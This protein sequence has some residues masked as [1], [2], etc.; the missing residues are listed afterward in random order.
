MANSLIQRQRET[1]NLRFGM[2]LH[3]NSATFQ[4]A[5]GDTV[6]WEYDCE[7]NDVPRQHPFS[8][9]DWNPQELD[10]AQWA[11][12]A[13]EAGAAFG[14]L[15]AKHHEGFCLW[16]THYTE[17]CV[18]SA[19]CKTDV[20]GAYVQA[21]R[22][23]GLLPGLYFS[24][25]DLTQG[26]GR[27]RCTP[28]DK[29]YIKG[30]ITELLT[31]YGEIPFLL[32]DGWAAPWGGPSYEALPFEE[33]DSWVKALQPDCLLIN[34]GSGCSLDHTDMVL[35]ENNAGQQAEDSFVGPGMGCD[36][37][38]GAW[39]WRK[40]DPARELRTSQWAAGRIAEMNRQN[41]TFILN[42]SPNQKGR[43]DANVEKV[44]QG[45]APLRKP[46]PPL[47][48]LPEGWLYRG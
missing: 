12:I 44:F 48:A 39:F 17:H 32:V 41:I 42:A 7:N 26:I 40:D 11:R 46:V 5:S 34:I 20:V 28:E 6:D 24:I 31:G 16:P 21:F 4:F 27:K 25:L 33:V 1:V 22:E 2:F 29:E 23:Q 8:P 14:V 47:A 36:I 38:T 9:A 18:R 37:L 45:I 35:Y 30:Q 13:K 10:C 43:I 3:F 15:T 19:A